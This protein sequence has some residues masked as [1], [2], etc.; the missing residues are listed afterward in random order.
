VRTGMNVA[1]RIVQRNLAV[2]LLY[3]FIVKGTTLRPKVSKKSAKD[4]I[5]SQ[6]TLEVLENMKK[7]A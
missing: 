4:V 7:T 5:T 2:K 3:P 6:I 1:L